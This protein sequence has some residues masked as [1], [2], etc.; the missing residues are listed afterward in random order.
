MI[1]RIL[2][3]ALTPTDRCT[4]LYWFIVGIALRKT[5]RVHPRIRLCVIIHN[6]ALRQG[7]STPPQSPSYPSYPLQRCVRTQL[8]PSPLITNP[9]LPAPQLLAFATDE[10]SIRVGETLAGLLNA[11]LVRTSF[12]LIFSPS[13]QNVFSCRVTRKYSRHL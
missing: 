6:S 11:T 9:V 3:I 7:R 8:H 4:I 12:R 2:G 13:S 1:S 10:L 5:P